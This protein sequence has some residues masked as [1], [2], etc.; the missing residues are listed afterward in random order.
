MANPSDRKIIKDSDQ[1]SAKPHKH[2]NDTHEEGGMLAQISVVYVH[3]SNKIY[4]K[5]YKEIYNYR[6]F[7]YFLFG[8]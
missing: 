1:C 6:F 2:E 3:R 7:I 8:L 5:S 4:Y